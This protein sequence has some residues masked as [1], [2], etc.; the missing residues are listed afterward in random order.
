MDGYL[1]QE[2]QVNQV[3][4]ENQEILGVEQAEHLIQGMSILQMKPTPLMGC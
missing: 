2:I 3:N 4:Q 1:A